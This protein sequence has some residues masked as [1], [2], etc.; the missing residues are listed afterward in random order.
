MQTVNPQLIP[1]RLWRMVDAHRL[2]GDGLIFGSA[3][4]IVGRDMKIFR[5][6][7]IFAD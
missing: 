3:S 2:N 5:L 7:P 6:L 1:V 4:D